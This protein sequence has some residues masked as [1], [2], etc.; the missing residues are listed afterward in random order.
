MKQ[1]SVSSGLLANPVRPGKFIPQEN[2]HIVVDTNLQSVDVFLK[3][4]T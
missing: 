3:D 1:K 4:K 2:V